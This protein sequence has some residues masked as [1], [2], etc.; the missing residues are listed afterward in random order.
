MKAAVR[1]T[2]VIV[3][4]CLVTLYMVVTLGTGAAIRHGTG[5]SGLNVIIHDSLRNCL[6]T[7]DE[8]K[9][10]IKKEA[11]EYIGRPIDGIDLVKIEKII[12]SRKAVSKSEAYMTRDGILNIEITQRT[13]VVMFRKGDSGFY[14]DSEGFL[15]PLQK[16]NPAGIIEVDGNIPLRTED[17]R[18]GKAG[19]P[20]A[21]KWLDGIM[22]MVSCID[23]H[24][25]FPAKISR[26]HVDGRGDIIIFTEE[27]RERFIFGN[28]DN[29]DMKF[30]RIKY[31]YSKIDTE[32][33]SGKYSSVNVKYDGQIICRK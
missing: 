3:F 23:S 31:Y 6:V 16:H 33:R 27:G 28:P 19:S 32:E 11:G 24:S 17:G 30:N 22:E 21:E 10:C 13:P 9:S 18:N 12:D 25:R 1:Y 2:L 20:E 26:L 5:C 29:I 15:F 7:Q 14:A 8:I 4:T